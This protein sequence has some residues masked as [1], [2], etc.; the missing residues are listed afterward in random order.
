MDQGAS[1]LNIRNRAG[2]DTTGDDP[3]LADITDEIFAAATAAVDEED[4]LSGPLDEISAAPVTIDLAQDLTPQPEAVIEEGEM[5][6]RSA[7]RWIVPTIAIL[8]IIAWTGGMIAMI[9]LQTFARLAPV[10]LTQLIAGLCVPPV[11]IGIIWLLAMRTSTAEA[12]RFGDVATRMRAE[13]AALEQAIAVM[14]RQVDENRARLG[15]QTAALMAMGDQANQRL[16]AISRGMAHEVGSADEQSRR[17]AEGITTAQNSLS[18]LLASLPRA[19]GEAGEMKSSLEGAGLAASE[20]AAALDAQI[21]ALTERGRVAD[22]LATG[23]AQKLAAHIA[24]MEATSETAG[25]RL[26][27]VTA[28]MSVA[29]DGLL[30]RTASAVDEARKGIEAQGAAMLAMVEANQAHLSRASTESVDALA[31]RI[32]LIEAA[33][34]RIGGRIAEQRMAGQALVADI[35]RDFGTVEDKVATFHNN[36]IERTQMLAAS[37]SAL[38]G[39]ADAMTEALRAGEDM[40]RRV[41]NTS[42]DLLTSLDAA[43]R[44]IDETLPEALK[45]LDKRIGESRKI[46]GSAKP[47]LLALVTAAESTHDAIEAIAQVLTNQ[48]QTLDQLTSTLLEALR[49]G[50]DKAETLGAAMDATISRTN[51]FTESAAPRLVEALM[52]VRETANTAAERARETLTSVIPDAARV[53][54][55]ASNQA[56]QRAVGGAVEQHIAGII[57]ATDAAVAAA[58]RASERLASQMMTIAETTSMVEARIDDAR[59]ENEKSD[60][61]SFGRRASLLIESL[62]S[63]SIDIAKSFS[64]DVADSAWAAY[65]KGDR[66]VFT[67]RAVRLIDTGE[68]REIARLYDEEP[69]FREQVNRY[70]H[71]FEAMLRTILAQRDG[72]PIGVTLLSSDMG[73][74]YVALAQAIERLRT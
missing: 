38:N 52:R 23:A 27:V 29:V 43:A 1:V 59:A 51:D 10:E 22:A 55:T 28:D 30:N 47:E 46:V 3:V 12:R 24:R 19:L 21:V 58:T 54:E 70:I 56:I 35:D 39:S 68:A 72:S 61:E 9:G 65:L 11:L 73:K 5:P 63:A 69:S 18:V 14:N 57:T 66:G 13:A 44:E 33:I 53:L 60:R 8:A 62:N 17:L 48:R 6:T 20:Q 37:I 41:I 50:E 7:W 45:R 42:E 32:D 36:G 64:S 2:K 25:T 34:D 74:L 31:Q 26:E 4:D 40:A 71:D 15:E 67:R 49:T 16:T